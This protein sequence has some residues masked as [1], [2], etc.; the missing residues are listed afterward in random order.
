MNEK[1]NE[2]G[3]SRKKQMETL[4]LKN[5]IVEIL[6]SLMILIT[7]WKLNIRKMF[8]LKHAYRW[9]AI[10][11]RIPGSFSHPHPPPPK[12]GSNSKIYTKR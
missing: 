5:T 8:F 9:N 6:K 4:E 7:E 12:L 1:R 11:I 3:N 10:P 2:N